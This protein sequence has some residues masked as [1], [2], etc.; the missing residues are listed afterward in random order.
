MASTPTDA[1]IMSLLEE[2]KAFTERYRD[3]LR[4]K[5]KSA[6]QHEDRELEVDTP[7]GH[8][9]GTIIRQFETKTI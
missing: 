1:E 8:K 5:R 7:S 9:L 2:K 6:Y 3:R 4:A